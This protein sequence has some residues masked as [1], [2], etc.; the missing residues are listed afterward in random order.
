MNSFDKKFFLEAGVNHF[1]KISYVNKILNFFIKSNFQNIT[2]MIHFEKF[3]K[4]FDKKGINFKLSNKFYSHIINYCKKRKKK[5]GF[6]VCDV[7]TFKTVSNIKVDF[8]KLLSVGINNQELI[9]ML[10]KKNKP[11]YISTG[12]NSNEKKI[13]NCI[14]LFGKSKNIRLLHSPM[15]YQS[16]ELNL[17]KINIFKKKFKLPIGYSNHF[18]SKEIFKVLSSYNPDSIFI[19]CKP[20]KKRGRVYP[21]DQHAFYFDELQQILANYNEIKKMHSPLS[22]KRLKINIFKNEIKL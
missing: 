22:K 21:D 11:I 17:N 2:F 6:S 12:F 10:K 3:Y 18:N 8:Y 5:F 13:N 4:K 1:G 20:I 15:T 7:E 9:K 16:N 14:R 19:Y